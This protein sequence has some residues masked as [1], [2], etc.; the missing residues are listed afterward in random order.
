MD[1]KSK[2]LVSFPAGAYGTYLLWLIYTLTSTDDIVPPFKRHGNSHNFYTLMRKKNIP[3]FQDILTVNLNNTKIH[4]NVYLL[5]NHPKTLKTH[6]MEKTLNSLQSMFK[7]VL[8]VYPSKSNYLLCIHNF[9]YKT[10]DPGQTIFTGPNSTFYQK[11]IY[12]NYPDAQNIEPD[13]LPDWL[14]REYFSFNIFPSWEDQ[15]EWF[16]PENYKNKNVLTIETSNLLYDLE[17][18]LE[19]IKDF[20]NLKWTKNI[21]EIL[22]IHK[23]NLSLQKYLH[24]DLLCEKILD[25]FFNNKPYSWNSKDLTIISQAYIQKKLRDNGYELQ[26]YNLNDFPTSTEN[27]KKILV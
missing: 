18:T 12:D 25:N 21:K 7:K 8:L 10:I 3:I 15:V 11:D 26:C 17:T 2:I 9:L 16:F 6:S 4:N 23:E 24:L 20:Y 19:T 13:N 1:C 14:L 5:K 27:I 22:P